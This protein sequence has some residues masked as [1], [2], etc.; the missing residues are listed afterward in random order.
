[1][2]LR[3]SFLIIG[4]RRIAKELNFHGVNTSYISAKDFCRY[5]NDNYNK[6]TDV[7][8][9]HSQAL[10]SSRNTQF[11]NNLDISHLLS[12]F[13]SLSVK[14]KY[15]FSSASVYGTQLSSQAINENCELEGQ[16]A[17]AKEKIYIEDQ[18]KNTNITVLRLSALIYHNTQTEASNLIDN[19]R[20]LEAGRDLKLVIEDNGEQIRDF[21]TTKFLA[22]LLTNEHNAQ[23]QSTINVANVNAIDIR[24]LIFKIL[25]KE[26]IARIKFLDKKKL[27]IHCSLN[28]TV[29][30][31]SL[32]F[33]KKD[34]LEVYKGLN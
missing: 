3:K 12:K 13:I 26:K 33:Y 24:S 8:L 18:L 21:C 28:T 34:I 32:P 31:R 11:N 19:I 7:I 6:F 9:G 4:G 25:P 23:F 14:K 20:H 2:V 27:K 30:Q 16:G 10:S 29:L 1:M 15:F 5:E 17:Y 22:N